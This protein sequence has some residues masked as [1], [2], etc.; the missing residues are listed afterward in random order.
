MTGSNNFC[1]N[2]NNTACNTQNCNLGGG[3]NPPRLWS[4]GN[5]VCLNDV[6]TDDLNMRRKA[7]TLLYKN[8]ESKFTAKKKFSQLVNGHGRY[9]KRCWASQTIR[10]SDPN[11]SNL[12]EKNQFTLLCPNTAVMCGLTSSADVPG[13]IQQLCMD[14]TI[15]LTRW[16]PRR[17]YRAG[18]S[19]WPE[20]KWEP[21][22]SGFP[23]GKSGCRGCAYNL[24]FK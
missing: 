3:P 11:T 12:H 9:R 14:P 18:G 15:P 21:G 23:R 22:M 5:N 13:S 16:I 10:V 8:N 4:R 19:K 20:W 2:G 17:T 24:V 7:E 6:S 1:I